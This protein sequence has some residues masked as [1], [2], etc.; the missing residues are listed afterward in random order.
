MTGD[1]SIHT[2]EHDNLE[3]SNKVHS[4]EEKIKKIEDINNNDGATAL[5]KQ[6]MIKSILDN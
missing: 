2:L 5:T 1:Y 6:V 4:L 3:L